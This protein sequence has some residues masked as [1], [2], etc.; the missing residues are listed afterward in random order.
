MF[1]IDDLRLLM[2]E[3]EDDIISQ[4]AA[5]TNLERTDKQVIEVKNFNDRALTRTLGKKLSSLKQIYT[6]CKPNLH[7]AKPRKRY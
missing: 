4:M 6:P 2:R 7:P 1:S 3:V 5:I